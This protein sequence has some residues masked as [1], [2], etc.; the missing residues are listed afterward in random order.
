MSPRT[1]IVGLAAA[2]ALA[3][4]VA[5]AA[6]RAESAASSAT[7]VHGGAARPKCP[8]PKIAVW[9]RGAGRGAA[10][11]RCLL[12]PAPS[13]GKHAIAKWRPSTEMWTCEACPPAEIAYS[14]PAAGRGRSGHCKKLPKPTHRR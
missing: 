6:M 13:C 14:T 3:S 8:P 1:A 12:P 4:P 11:W 7:S 2:L 5:P 9:A 10:G